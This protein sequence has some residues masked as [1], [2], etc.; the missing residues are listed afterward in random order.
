MCTSALARSTKAARFLGLHG[1]MSLIELMVVLLI[2]AIL[3]GIGVPSYRGYLLRAQRTEAKDALVRLANN[4][5]RYYLQFNSYTNDVT[6]LGF[7]ASG[8]TDQG[9]YTVAV[10][11]AN[12]LGFTAT[13]TPSTSG[14]M[15]DD[16]LC[17]WFSIDEAGTRNAAD[18]KCW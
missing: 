1:G 2:I 4:Q 14:G 17:P 15:A 13:A 8:A 12:R 7:P 10:T 9:L 3:A 18:G 5:E 6:L 11:S 16:T